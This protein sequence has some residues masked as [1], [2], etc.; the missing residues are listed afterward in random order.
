[1]QYLMLVKSCMEVYFYL[2]T[3]FLTLCTPSLCSVAVHKSDK[4]CAGQ[5]YVQINMSTP[6]SYIVHYYMRVSGWNTW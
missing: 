6:L 2:S 3:T 5:L 1:M 4:N